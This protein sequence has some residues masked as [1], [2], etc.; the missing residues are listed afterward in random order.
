[1]KHLLEKVGIINYKYSLLKDDNL[2]NIFKILRNAHDEVN[3]HSK[4]IFELISSKNHPFTNQF[5]DLFLE[6]IEATQFDTESCNVYKEYKN[7]DLLLTNKNQAI[8]IENKIWAGDQNKQLE[9]YYNIIEREGYNDIQIFYLTPHGTPPSTQSLGTLKSDIPI[10]ISY[11]YHIHDW[12]ENCI[13]VS[14]KSPKIRETII[15]YQNLI[16]ELTGN[17]INMDER[18]ELIDL[19]SENDNI[20]K[21]FLIANNWIHV[22]WHTEWDFWNELEKKVLKNSSYNTKNTHKFT[23][24]KL[25]NVI[26]QSRSRK[27]WYGLKWNIGEYKDSEVFLAI[28]RGFG[29]MYYGITVATKVRNEI[30][31]LI[32]DFC[33]VGESAPW[34]GWKYFSPAINFE[35]F[36]DSNT[37]KLRNNQY[38]KEAIDKCW[39]QINEVIMKTQQALEK[40][41]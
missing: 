32:K 13:Q 39:E 17:S 21:A 28:E 38:R 2:F 20:E 33:E 6:A 12:L 30:A 5:I 27:P 40:K 1:M 18:K 23:A 22:K 41:K 7:I 26:H 19:L 25:N 3:L 10:K 29:N 4:F 9:R 34:S 14:S 15:Q 24:E 16:K 31:E 35:N 11:K 37:L 8:I 36:S